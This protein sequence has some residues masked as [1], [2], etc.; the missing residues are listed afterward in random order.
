MI[1]LPSLYV[2][3]QQEGPYRSTFLFSVTVTLVTVPLGWLLANACFRSS[4]QEVECFY[5]LPIDDLDYENLKRPI[6]CLVL[7][8]LVFT[9]YYIYEV[10]TVPLFYLLR[11]PGDYLELVTLREES[12]KLLDSRFTY[13]YFILRSVL[14]PFLILVTLGCYLRTRERLWFVLFSVT[15]FMGLFFASLSLAKAPVSIIFAV[16]GLFTYLYRRGKLGKKLVI[17]ILVLVLLFPFF[18]VLGISTDSVTVQMATLALAS[19]VFYMPAEVVY[20]YFEV[21]PQQTN[22]LHGRSIDKL[23]RAL[24]EAPFPIENHVGTYAY[25][26]YQDTVSANGAFIAYLYADFGVAGV[27]LGG[28]LAGFVMQS[29]GIWVIRRR[30]TIITIAAYAFMMYAFW[31]LHSISLAVVIA[32]N[33][34]ALIIILTVLLSR[35]RGKESSAPVRYQGF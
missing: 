35:T 9:A 33:G 5:F 23:A 12:F 19:R 11:N 27:L 4:A 30:K 34:V 21:F 3:S 8:A 13:I 26:Q 25:P 28:I 6:L 18:V 24:G 14:Y 7:G 17:T 15:T 1:F 32:S 2:Y 16:I 22:F 20:Y 31:F 10:N 29:V